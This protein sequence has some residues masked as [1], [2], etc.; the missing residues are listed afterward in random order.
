MILVLATIVLVP[1]SSLTV[2]TCFYEAIS[3]CSELIL[4][5]AGHA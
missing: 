4:S 1:T 2:H 5:R 3:K